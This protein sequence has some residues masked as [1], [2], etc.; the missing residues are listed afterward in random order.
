MKD[1]AISRLRSGTVRVRRAALWM[2]FA[3]VLLIPR[4]N[5]LRRQ[6]RAWNF[7]RIVIGFAGA[8]ILGVG[9]ERGHAPGLLVAGALMLLFAF[10]LGPERSELSVDA[11]VRELGALIAIDVGRYVDADGRR[12]RVKLFIGADQL[13]VLDTALQTVL[14]VPLQQIRTVVVEPAGTNWTFR[15]DCEEHT[16][17]FIYEGTFAE[18][19]ARVAE[20]TLRSRLYR[21]LPILRESAAG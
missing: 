21:E 13:W 2:I 11:R 12:N 4:V 7:V 20:A 17:E 18:H 16:A 14:E 19:L 5:R 9:L 8:A 3:L 1:S 10:F 15:V 6:R